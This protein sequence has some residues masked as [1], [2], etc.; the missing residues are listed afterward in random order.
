MKRFEEKALMQNWQFNKDVIGFDQADMDAD[1]YIK[2]RRH[3][4]TFALEVN[5][6]PIAVILTSMRI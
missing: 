2:S 1:F 5:L 4:G 6:M 3:G